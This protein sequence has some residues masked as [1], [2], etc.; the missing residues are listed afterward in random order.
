M[1]PAALS[2]QK[3]DHGLEHSSVAESVDL[4]DTSPASTCPS[5]VTES[6]AFAQGCDE[7]DLDTDA[8]LPVEVTAAAGL[9]SCCPL[10]H[11]NLSEEAAGVELEECRCL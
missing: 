7:P 9:G 8:G 10:G 11:R 6:N 4:E 3:E 2:R 5:L 1:V